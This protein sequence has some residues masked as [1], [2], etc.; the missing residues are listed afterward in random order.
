MRLSLTLS[1][2]I[3]RQFISAFLAVMMVIMGVIF[4]F[5]VI[6]LIRR[7]ASHGDAGFWALI[8]M[9]LLKLPQMVHI[10]LPFGVMIGSMVALWRLSRSHELVVARA[11]GISA[12][13]FLTPLLLFVALTGV[14]EITAFNPLAAIMY[15]R[16][17]KMQD[18]I[19]L[20]RGSALDVSEQGLWLREG[21]EQRQVVVHADAV[22]QDG[23]IL[24]LYQVHLF[25]YG[26][27]EAF[28]SRL[29]AARGKL[30]GSNFELDDVWQMKGGASSAHVDHLVIPTQLTIERVHDNFAS[31]ETMS[32]WQ[33]PA[34]IDFFE[35][36]G[37]AANKHRMYLQ[38]LL[39]SPLLYCGMT[40]LAAVFS[41]TLSN[42]AGGVMSRIG[43]GVLAGFVVY[44]FSKISYAFGMSATLPSWLAAW[45]PGVI[46]SLI[47]ISG[48]L[49]QEDG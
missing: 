12:W 45:S 14:A 34:F 39:A 35:R 33:L 16:F 24:N 2:Y 11:A 31:P 6:E 30:V 21:D 9:A 18:E 15:A 8:S 10:I 20:N 32:F 29:H 19:L 28:A 22:R 44:F 42:R 41:L 36:A 5:D 23:L 40:L 26:R 38:S 47:G 37:F 13:Q 17:E 48:L 27:N 4:L 25:F 1:F 7:S 43:G 3:I 49:H 46:I